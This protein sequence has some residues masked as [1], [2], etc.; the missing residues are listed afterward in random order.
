MFFR[1]LPVSRVSLNKKISWVFL[2]L[3]FFKG[4]F[5]TGHMLLSA[6]PK[7]TTGGPDFVAGFFCW[8]CPCAKFLLRQTDPAGPI[9][10]GIFS[11]LYFVCC[12]VYLLHVCVLFTR[13]PLGG[14]RCEPAA[15]FGVFS[16]C[17]AGLRHDSQPNVSP[18]ERFNTSLLH[19]LFIYVRHV[20]GVT[21]YMYVIGE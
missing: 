7:I 16:D 11:S 13:F 20:S 21:V 4:V 5:E 1:D 15:R 19:W 14:R 12:V 18:S 3:M 8:I 17:D 9:L 10:A 6:A 2:V